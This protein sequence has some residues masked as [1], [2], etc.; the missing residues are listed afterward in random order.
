[1]NHL[2]AEMTELVEA[3]CAAPTNAFGYG[4]WSHHVSQVVANGRQLA[5]LLGADAEI[6]ELAALL[7]DYASICDAALYPEHHLHSARVA[8]ELLGARGYPAE[9]IAAVQHCIETHRGSLRARRN[10]VEAV[11]LAN[12]DALSHIQQVPSLLYLAYVQRQMSI[13]AGAEWVAQKLERTWRKLDPQVQ[14]LAAPE[15]AAALGVLTASS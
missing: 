9:R 12:A 8:G 11:C 1:M 7:H 14:A 4:I 5:P 15:Y 13:D 6:V 3:A 2:I 10:T